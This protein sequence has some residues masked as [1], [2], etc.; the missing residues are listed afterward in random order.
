MIMYKWQNVRIT[1]VKI[2]K[3]HSDQYKCRSYIGHEIKNL[4]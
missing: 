3:K 2:R 4:R 1:Y